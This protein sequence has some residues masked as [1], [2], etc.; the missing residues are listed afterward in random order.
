M[1][2]HAL[3]ISRKIEYG[4]RAMVCLAA[5]TPG[6]LV[7]F[8]EIARR[9]DVPEDFLAK[10]LKTLVGRGLVTSARGAHGGYRLAKPPK[11]ITFLAVIE[12][13][14]GPFV[15]SLCG[16]LG[17]EHGSCRMTS[18]CTMYGVWQRGQEASRPSSIPV[19]HAGHSTVCT[20]TGTSSVSPELHLN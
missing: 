5:Q 2:H 10:I 14:E 19:R 4:L 11:D 9:M 12:A 3:Q 1:Q 16:S 8:R 15:V 6:T 18:A 20:A 7:P 17:E 13:V